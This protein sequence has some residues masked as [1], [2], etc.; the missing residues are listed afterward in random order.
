ML[1]EL[2]RK[3]NYNKDRPSTSSLNFIKFD[4]ISENKGPE[5]SD[6]SE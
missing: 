2:K 4:N 5:S 6:S 3:D 1:N